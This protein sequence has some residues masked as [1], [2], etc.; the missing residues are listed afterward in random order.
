MLSVRGPAGGKA[1][2][3]LTQV[4]SRL[5]LLVAVGLGF[6]PQQPE[7]AWSSYKP[8]AVPKA[9]AVLATFPTQRILHPASKEASKME[10]SPYSAEWKQILGP[11]KSKERHLLL[12]SRAEE[13]KGPRLC[14]PQV[15]YLTGSGTVK[16]TFPI[17]QAG[18]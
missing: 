14:P 15:I 16:K 12:R 13:V 2:S 5:H 17:C 11:S 7:A 10:S 6:C 9:A 3:K 8:P 1:S 4:T 18:V